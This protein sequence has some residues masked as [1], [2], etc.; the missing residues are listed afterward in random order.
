VLLVV[1][2]AMAEG[3][4]NDEFNLVNVALE[5]RRCFEGGNVRIDKYIDGYRELMR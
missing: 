5:F 1:E 3:S 4:V 2:G